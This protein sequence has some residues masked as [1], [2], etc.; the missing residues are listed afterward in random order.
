MALALGPLLRRPMQRTEGGAYRR[1]ATLE[2]RCLVS[3]L[4]DVEWLTNNKARYA[5]P[6][7]S[8]STP[9]KQNSNHS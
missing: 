9:E 7:V 8:F 1:V 2:L 6:L 3:D 4:D 5:Y